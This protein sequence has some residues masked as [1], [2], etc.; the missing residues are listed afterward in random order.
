MEFNSPNPPRMD[1]AHCSGRWTRVPCCRVTSLMIAKER[2][3]FCRCPSSWSVPKRTF[4][5]TAKSASTMRSCTHPSWDA[6][7]LRRGLP[8]SC[9]LFPVYHSSSLL[10][11]RSS[12][13]LLRGV[14]N[15]T[16]LLVIPLPG[17]LDLW[18]SL[19][20]S[21]FLFFSSSHVRFRFSY[22]Q[23][24]FLLFFHSCSLLFFAI[25]SPPFKHCVFLLLS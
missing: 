25:L 22:S 21:L 16:F 9:P 4:S 12:D 24:F 2:S 3:S 14:I 7:T 10:G 8:S 6:T 19:S 17:A 11:Q 15:P 5:R 1:P 13:P 23:F 18:N 20:L